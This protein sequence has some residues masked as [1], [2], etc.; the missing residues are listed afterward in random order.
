MRRTNLLPLLFFAFL[1]GGCKK[2]IDKLK[3]DYVVKAMVD[4][5]WAVTSFTQD[6]T[7]ITSSF[8]GY[9]FKYYDSPRKVDARKN[10]TLEMT[11]TWDGDA[12]TLT[13]WANFSGAGAPLNLINGSWHINDGGWTYVVAT[14]TS[15][16]SIKTMRLD[17]Q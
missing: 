8:D 17:K 11:G 2:T 3:E 9:T 7:D 15:G 1:L 5:Q 14:Q 4:G 16:T 12:A 10:G 13:T 6:G